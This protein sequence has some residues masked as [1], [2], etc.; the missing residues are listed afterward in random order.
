MNWRAGGLRGAAGLERLALNEIGSK[1]AFRGLATGGLATG[2]N[3]DRGI[4]TGKIAAAGSAPG[5]T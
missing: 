5:E 1:T 4:A 2:G 3:S